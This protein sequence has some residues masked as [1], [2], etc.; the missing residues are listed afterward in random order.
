M[1][2]RSDT[3][4][5]LFNSEGKGLEIGPSHNP[6]MPKREG[7]DVEILDY[8]S[9]DDLREKYAEAGQDVSA[10]EDVDYIS[11]GRSIVD[12]VGQRHRYD[13]IVASHVIEHVPD[14]VSFLL[15]CHA[16]LKPSGVLV[17]AIPD[18]RCCFDILRPVSTIGQVLQAYADRRARPLPGIIFD[19]V[20][21]GRKRDGSIGWLLAAE[22]K[23]E[24]VRNIEDAWNMYRAA[25][26]T[27]DY[28]DVHC[29]IFVPSSFRLIVSALN[30]LGVTAMHEINFQ[31]VGHEFYAVLQAGEVRTQ[32][33]DVGELARQA[34]FEERDAGI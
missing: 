16:L 29:W 34:T 10:I 6:L 21:Y 19:D 27:S 33:L 23:L 7:F 1:S 9:A 25:L 18:K 20:A 17:L 24:Q 5:A 4:R 13:W 2:Y 30:G 8:L 12:V 11:D 22:G 31:S 15:D 28:I 14:L 26:Q 3:L 32:S